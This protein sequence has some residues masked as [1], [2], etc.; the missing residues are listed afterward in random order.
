[1]LLLF[2]SS[3]LEFAPSSIC[4]ETN[5]AGIV[6]RITDATQAGIPSAAVVVTNT[7]TNAKRSKLTNEIGEFS[8]PNL[9]PAPKE[10]IRHSPRV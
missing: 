2:V 4:Q 6:G 10:L 8:V 7:G 3:F 5:S 1:M 9:A